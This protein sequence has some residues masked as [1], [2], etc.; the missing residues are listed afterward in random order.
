MLPVSISMADGNLT[1]TSAGKVW[2]LRISIRTALNIGF[3]FSQFDLSAAAEMYIFNEARTVMD[4][5]IVKNRFTPTTLP[6]IAP[7]TATSI[8][9][10]IIEPGNTGTFQSSVAIQ[11]VGAGFQDIEDLGGSEEVSRPPTVNC[12]PHIM[13]QPA[14]IPTASI[15]SP[16]V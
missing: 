4:S 11:K 5:N 1:S 15:C 6:G 12:D 14:K 9:I 16:Y 3:V 13:C 10:Y 7:F 8:I 2:T